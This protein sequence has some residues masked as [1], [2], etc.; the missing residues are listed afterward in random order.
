MNIIE[1]TD[2]EIRALADQR[3]KQR[4]DP[5]AE[6]AA[7]PAEVE[8]EREENRGRHQSQPDRIEP[9]LLRQFRRAVRAAQVVI[10][11]GLGILGV[12]PMKEMR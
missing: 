9:L 1:R 6:L 5:V 7:L 10:A 11:S 3:R 8:D 4:S 2:E 12:T